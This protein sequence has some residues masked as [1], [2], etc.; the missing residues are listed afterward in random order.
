[1]KIRKLGAIDIGS[2][3]VRLLINF[4]YEE[5][6]KAPIFNKTSIVRMPIR[7]GQDVFIDGKISDLNAD[8]ICDAMQSYALM[9]KVYGI[10]HYRAYATSA[11]R[12]STN[13]KEIVEKI[14]ERSGLNIEVITGKTEAELI[15]STE[16]SAF[17]KDNKTYLY[18]DVGG[19]S[20]ELTLLKDN[21]IFAS[22]SFGVGTVRLLENK[23]D[24]TTF[25]EMQKW[26]YEH[27]TDDE[28]QDFQ[29]DRIKDRIWPPLVSETA[30]GH[31]KSQP[32][33]LSSMSVDNL[34]ILRCQRIIELEFIIGDGFGHGCELELLGGG[35]VYFSF[36]HISF[37]I[38]GSTS[39]SPVLP[40]GCLCICTGC[41][42]RCRSSSGSVTPGTSVNHTGSWPA[43]WCPC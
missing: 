38:K 11:M 22:K 32:V 21:K 36:G 18:V 9:M 42:C 43:R 19:G 13:G 27:V 39:I 16:L 28:I 34:N 25:P 2:N 35:K 8:R 12:E 3:A 20:T 23:V 17:V 4:V 5:E 40:F 24:P 6:G 26:I 33:V 15:F 30:E 1:M 7:L 41:A 14:K 37:S 10:E 31:S 29:R